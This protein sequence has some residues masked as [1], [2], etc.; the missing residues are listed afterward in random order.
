[1]SNYIKEITALQEKVQTNKEELI[2]LEEKQ[3]SLKADKDKILTSLKELDISEEDL[4]NKIEIMEEELKSE[5]EK[6]EEELE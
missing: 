6:I 5:I 3:K 4:G 1:M 2:R